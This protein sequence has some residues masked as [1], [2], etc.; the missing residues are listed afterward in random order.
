MNAPRDPTGTQ[1]L[2]SARDLVGK[3]A[4]RLASRPTSM[5]ASRPTSRLVSWLA[6]RRAS[7]PASMLASRLAG[8]SARTVAHNGDILSQGVAQTAKITIILI[9]DS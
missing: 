3:S 1:Q 6:N 4:S 7:R 5:L 8:F 2:S 9:A